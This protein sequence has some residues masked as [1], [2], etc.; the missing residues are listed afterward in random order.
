MKVIFDWKKRKTFG[1][2]NY[3][4]KFAQKNFCLN[5]YP[6]SQTIVKTKKEI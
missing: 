5:M 6:R 4:K 2:N 1:N 3:Y